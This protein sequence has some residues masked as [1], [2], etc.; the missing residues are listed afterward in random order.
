MLDSVRGA[1]KVRV[2][3][4]ER[5]SA[6]MD[7]KCI[8]MENESSDLNGERQCKAGFSKGYKENRKLILTSI[9]TVSKRWTLTS[10][11]TVR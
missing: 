10:N 9:F 1:A 7:N 3:V 6:R 2:D 8:M 11:V 4:A 5:E